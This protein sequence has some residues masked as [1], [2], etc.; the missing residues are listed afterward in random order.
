MWFK[1]YVPDNVQ[2]VKMTTATAITTQL[3]KAYLLFF[4]IARLI[5]EIYLPTEFLV[6]DTSCR[7]RHTD[8]GYHDKAAT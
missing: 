5:N 3:G 1:S 4:C 7:F 2:I 6:D 8:E